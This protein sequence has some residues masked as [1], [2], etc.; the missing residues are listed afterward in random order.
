MAPGPVSVPPEQWRHLLRATLR[1]CSYLP[2]PIAR[3]YMRDHVRERYRHHASK[4]KNPTSIPLPKQF[5]LRRAAR[6]ALSVLQRANEGYLRPL[7]RV[8]LLSYGRIGKRRHELLEPLLTPEVP[9]DAEAVAKMLQQPSKFEDGWQPP[10]IV[11][12]L[13]RSQQKNG[14]IGKYGIRP[15]VKTLAPKIPAENSWG[16]PLPVS[17]RRNIRKRWYAAAL[18][19]LLPPLP[20]EEARLLQNLISGTQPWAPVKRRKGITQTPT[21]QSLDAKFLV[22]GPQKGHTFSTFASGRPHNITRRFMRRVWERLSCMIPRMEMTAPNRARFE[23]GMP[24]RTRR[25]MLTVDKEQ[26]SGLFAGLNSDGKVHDG[27]HSASGH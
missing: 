20:E 3:G 5:N 23:W 1:E 11:V 19:S 13:L 25:E 10:S 18:D 22:E 4:W 26:A 7:E 12:D 15:Q 2:D 6:H 27:Q 14:I 17:R 21:T 9:P 24:S 16:R 8:M